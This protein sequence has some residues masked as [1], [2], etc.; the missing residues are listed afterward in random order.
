MSST[1]ALQLESPSALLIRLAKCSLGTSTSESR[2]A[3]K[4]AEMAKDSLRFRWT[5]LL[6]SVLA[7]PVVLSFSCDSTPLV[8]RESF[9]G[10]FGKHFKVCRRG[11]QS[12]HFDV[13]RAGLRTSRGQCGVLFG[14]PARMA[15]QTAWTAFAGF[16]ELI[17]PLRE[18]GHRGLAIS[19]HVEDRALHGALD[20]IMTSYHNLIDDQL[21]TTMGAGDARLL[22]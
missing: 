18:S 19:H 10:M 4:L 22:R 9:H 21:S 15:D 11:R 6:Q 5:R 16:L 17:K 12:G 8:T 14:E 3:R 1:R 2:A 7:E 20:R 13:Q